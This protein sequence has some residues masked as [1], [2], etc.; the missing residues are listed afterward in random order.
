MVKKSG[1][2]AAT[3]LAAPGLGQGAAAAH[4]GLSGGCQQGGFDLGFGSDGY[5]DHTEC[6]VN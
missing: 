3:V 4:A 5:F 1:T 2:P 6:V